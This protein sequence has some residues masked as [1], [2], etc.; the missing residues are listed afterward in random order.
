MNR[1]SLST[2]TAGLILLT[3]VAGC[4]GPDLSPVPTTATAPYACDG[5]P[6]TSAELITG[7]PV[8]A[9][10]S[11]HNWGDDQQPFLCSLVS[12]HG[13]VQVEEAPVEQDSW[14]PTE[15]SVIAAMQA[16]TD[17]PPLQLDAPGTGYTWGGHTAG[18]VCNGRVITVAIGDSVSGRDRLADATNLLASML[19]WA[20][21]G[22][23]VPEATD[24]ETD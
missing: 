23:D 4:S 5:V 14:G 12:E 3:L 6:R 8:T 24:A 19:P 21:N 10:V 1:R 15:A 17:D 9:D 18:W 16:T 22:E 2:G 20:C 13:L 7:E 11:N